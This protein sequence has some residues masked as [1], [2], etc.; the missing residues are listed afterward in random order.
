M[1][2]SLFHQRA[3]SRSQKGT[4]ITA[5]MPVSTAPAT[6]AAFP[7]RGYYVLP[8]AESGAQ[9]RF[10]PDRTSDIDDEIPWP[11]SAGIIPAA[12]AAPRLPRDHR[13]LKQHHRRAHKR[14]P[15]TGP[16]VS[17]WSTRRL[18][19]PA[20]W[21]SS[22]VRWLAP[23][24]CRLARQRSAPFM[25]YSTIRPIRPMAKGALANHPSR[26]ETFL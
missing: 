8:A 9:G 25:R 5:K 13:V 12:T 23:R 17:S 24:F 19:V 1:G 15:E 20:F 21:S 14:I 10:F 4:I 16:P 3:S 11:S 2:P 6:A 18:F 22:A 7:A 26:R